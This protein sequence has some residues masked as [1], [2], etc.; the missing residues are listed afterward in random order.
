MELDGLVDRR[1]PPPNRI[2]KHDSDHEEHLTEGAVMIAFAMHL[3]RW[4]GATLVRLHPDGEHGKNF[5]FRGWLTA[6]GFMRS[7][8]TGTTAYAGTYTNAAAQQIIVKP[9]PGVGDVIAET[10]SGAIFAECKGG[11]LNTRHSGQ[12][13]RL[14]KGLC[15]AVGL[16]MAAPTAGRQIAVV[17]DTAVTA[18][19]AAR[20]VPRCQL[21][22]IEIALVGA[23][24]NVRLVD[25]G[26]G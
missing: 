23:R 19:L 22:G 2:G 10:P 26:S 20:L 12:T 6:N 11:V 16:L 15:E 17:P 5:D 7:D 8:P 24:G 21:A 4:E 13:S 1:A 9:T 3:L 25:H 18:R 14:Y